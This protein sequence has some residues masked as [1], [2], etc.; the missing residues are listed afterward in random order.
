[1]RRR[2]YV[3][4][5]QGYNRPVGDPRPEV[6]RQSDVG[7]APS[8]DSEAA[9]TEKSVGH[10]HSLSQY[11]AAAALVLAAPAILCVLAI[12]ADYALAVLAGALL[13]WWV[14]TFLRHE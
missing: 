4:S 9:A 8:E 2:S 6:R 12:A 14:G 5:Q 11:P 3:R 7:S 13:V 10:P 1:M